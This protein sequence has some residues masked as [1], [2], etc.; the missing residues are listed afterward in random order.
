MIGYRTRRM[1]MGAQKFV[2]VALASAGLLSFLWFLTPGMWVSL[3]GL[4]L[5]WSGWLL[6]KK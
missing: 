3:I 1:K 6:F 4:G 5:I 2:G